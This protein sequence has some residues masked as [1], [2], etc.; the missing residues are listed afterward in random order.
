M[1]FFIIAV[2]VYA[3][4]ASLSE[5]LAEVLSMLS[6]DE[7]TDLYEKAGEPLGKGDA[8]EVLLS[9]AENGLSGISFE[10][11]FSGV[12]G[13]FREVWK[14]FLPVLLELLA[15]QLILGLAENAGGM[16]KSILLFGRILLMTA[17]CG[18]VMRTLKTANQAVVSFSEI[19]ERI[20]PVAS[21]MLLLMGS[22]KSS[23]VMTP[24]LSV[25]SGTIAGLIRSLILPMLT[26]SSALA[27]CEA[28]SEKTSGIKKLLMSISKGFLAFISAVFLAF[29]SINGF[30]TS[31]IDSV[32]MK[33]A[34]FAVDKSI[35][36]VGGMLSDSFETFMACAGLI[37]NAAGIMSIVILLA[38]M[39]GPVLQLLSAVF[40]LQLAGG[41]ASPFADE[42]SGKLLGS[43]AAALKLV[44]VSLLVLYAMAFIV[45]ALFLGVFGNV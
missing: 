39:L 41:L 38:V 35:P 23:A 27:L 3:E 34:K 6:V 40:L 45:I 44:L 37:R 2:P 12:F 9:L 29:G 17:A 25:L 14:S 26:A 30:I 11:L 43:A 18:V 19:M 22:F 42:K 5:A 7:L 16:K 28:F 33:T 21:G 1:I 32:S 24:L 13:A 36:I 8:A 15:L 31:R 10:G 20:V 4:E